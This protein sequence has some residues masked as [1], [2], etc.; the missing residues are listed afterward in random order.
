MITHLIGK[1]IEK[2]QSYLI[3]DCNGVGYYVNISSYTYSFLLKKKIE[4]IFTKIYTYL[5]IREK[6]HVLYGFFDKKERKVFSYLISINGVGPSLAITMLSSLTPK[7]IEEY[8]YKKD[9]NIF[10]KKVKGIGKKIAKKII[11]ELEDKIFQKKEKISIKEKVFSN[12]KIKEV[13]SVLNILGFSH[14]NSKHFLDDIINKYPN[15]SVEDLVKEFL[16]KK[17]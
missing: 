13:I 2:C 6:E 11:I 14:K 5:L 17:N 1:V 12:N 16:K 4:K 10:V 7:E 8:V 9:Y 3:I 15:Y